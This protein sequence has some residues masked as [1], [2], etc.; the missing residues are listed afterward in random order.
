MSEQER[1][2]GA[3]DSPL[4]DTAL[5]IIDLMREHVESLLP[6]GYVIARAADVLT[7]TIKSDI[8]WICAELE[9]TQEAHGDQT[10]DYQIGVVARLRAIANGGTDDQ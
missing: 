8:N 5:Q 4:L 10:P 2:T 6:E 1:T 7:D 3:T 9:L